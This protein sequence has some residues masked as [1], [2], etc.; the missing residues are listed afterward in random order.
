MKPPLR[1]TIR[2]RPGITSTTFVRRSTIS[3]S[4]SAYR[5][6]QSRRAVAPPSASEIMSLLAG[7]EAE[8][9]DKTAAA[10]TKG[11]DAA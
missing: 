8:N 1:Q 9:A 3:Q 11:D 4:L 10:L 6:G 5:V 2:P 7:L